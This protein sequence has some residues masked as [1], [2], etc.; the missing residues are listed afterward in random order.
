MAEIEELKRLVANKKQTL[1]ELK[2]NLDQKT[3][4]QQQIMQQFAPRVLLERLSDAVTVADNE[5][6]AIASA[7]LDG[8]KDKE[9]EGIDEVEKSLQCGLGS[10]GEEYKEFIKRFSEKRRIYHMRA[11]KKE[12]MLMSLNR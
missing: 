2:F 12:S 8:M 3:Q 11:A 7:F 10:S 5:S 1:A 4:R 9:G 6:E